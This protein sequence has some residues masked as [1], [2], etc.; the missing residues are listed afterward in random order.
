MSRSHV[1]LSMTALAGLL[2]ATPAC[3]QSPATVKTAAASDPAATIGGRTITIEEIDRKW[4]ELDAASYMKT[5]QEMFDIRRRVIDVMVGDHVLGDA[6]KARGLTTEALLAEELPKRVG[7][8]TEADL[9]TTYDQMRSQMGGRTLDEVRVALAQF[10]MQ[11][12]QTE[13]RQALV[14]ELRAKATGIEVLLEPPRY[15]VVSADHEP[16]RGP[17]SAPVE[18]VEFSDFQCPYCSRVNPTLDRLRQTFGD[19]IKIVFR[20]FPL[21]SIH[22][23]AFQAAEAAECAREQ[24]KFW[25]F[26]DRLF[27][28]QRALALDDLKR[29]AGDL[30]LDM[31][32][33]GACVEGGQAKARVDADLEAGQ[34]LGISST[35]AIFINGRHV[36]GAQPYEV[37]EAIIKDE[38]ARRK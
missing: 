22:P 1:A 7:E 31:A 36:A 3:A 19:D 15:T 2:L 8:I 29:H 14:T 24:G 34:A 10:L 38:L 23:Q 35:P 21:T 9:Q 20:D 16:V 25:E 27:A 26:H 37:F 30:G 6:A 12:R 28:N 11:Q 33:F 4:Q 18:I 17:A 5:T 13:A 32:A